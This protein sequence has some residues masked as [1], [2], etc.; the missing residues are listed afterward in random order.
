MKFFIMSRNDRII[1]SFFFFV[2][3]YLYRT[4]FSTRFTLKR[5][6]VHTYSAKVWF[7]ES[8]F[9]TNQVSFFI[10]LVEFVEK[11]RVYFYVSNCIYR[12]WRRNANV[13]RVLQTFQPFSLLI[14]YTFFTVLLKEYYSSR[15]KFRRFS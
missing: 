12:I 7:K 1:I 3:I 10:H 15:D 5:R 8:C 11:F 2:C 13:D 9:R 6:R 4:S 14:G